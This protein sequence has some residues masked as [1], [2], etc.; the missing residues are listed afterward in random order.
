MAVR[1]EVNHVRVHAAAVVASHVRAVLRR[2][3]EQRVLSWMHRDQVRNVLLL[4][5]LL[6]L[7]RR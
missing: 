5:L 6:L 2:R 1:A 4:L 7:L 3:H